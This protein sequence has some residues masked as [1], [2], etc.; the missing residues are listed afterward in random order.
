MADPK[1]FSDVMEGRIIT[2][3]TPPEEMQA[4]LEQALIRLGV[5]SGQL[6]DE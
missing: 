1:V 2:K 6:E 3:E 5:A 4:M